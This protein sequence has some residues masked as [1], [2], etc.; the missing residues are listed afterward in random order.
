MLEKITVSNWM[1]HESFEADF[2]PG[3]NLVYGLNASGKSSLAKAIAFNLTGFLSRKVDPRRD[4]KQVCFVDLIIQG[5]N[6]KYLVRRT[7]NKGSRIIPALFIYEADNQTDAIY[8]EDKAERFLQQIFGMNPDIFQRIIYMKEEDVHEFLAKPDGRVLFEI[9]RLI[10]LEKVHKISNDMYDLERSLKVIHR[11]VER[12]RKEL[13]TAVKRELGIKESKTDI[14]QAKK[15]LEEIAFESEE[16]M[17]LQ[18]LY[19]CRRELVDK[20][21]EIKKMAEEQNEK[22]LEAKLIEKQ[23]SIKKEKS[24]IED[25]IK[26]DKGFVDELINSQGTFKAKKELKE[27]IIEDLSIDLESGEIP[28]CPTCGR[29]MD[30]KLVDAILKKLKGEIKTLDKDLQTKILELKTARDDI[31]K[32][33]R[34]IEELDKKIG[35]FKELKVATGQILI[36]INTNESE[37]AV[38]RKKGYP[39]TIVAIESKID[40]LDKEGTKLDRSI[41]R[42]EG[43]KEATEE[44]VKGKIKQEEEIKHKMKIV[45][46]IRRAANETTEKQR[47]TYTADVKSIA[48]GI[49]KQYKGV[50][51]Q[52]EWDDDFVPKARTLSSERELIAYEMSGS[53]KFLIML[54]I[55]LAIQQS[56]E[57][58]QLLI[59]DEPCQHLDEANGRLFR[60]ILISVDENKIGQSIVFTFNRDF[61]EGKWA[62]VIKLSEE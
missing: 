27:K 8:T 10:G 40:V 52:I 45:E 58:F 34:E 53:E 57:K 14:K 59:I 15:R 12:D 44:F 46:L 38:L 11:N 7:I 25:D 20:I 47:E 55:R 13:E 39:E 32:K 4:K 35:V 3:K 23:M 60:D 18:G 16:L 31:S 61:L 1:A 33:E 2:K 42:T 51:W 29:E 19:Y 62:N 30:Q 28:D 41:S 21:N 9:D 36:D 49:W 6:K 26:K 17:K 22:K 24:A 56:L 43:A 48:E 37:I 50:P 5:K 54:A